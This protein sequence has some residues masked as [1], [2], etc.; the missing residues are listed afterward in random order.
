MSHFT[1]YADYLKHWLFK[2]VRETAMR[3]T[4]WRCELCGNPAT[5]VHHRKYPKPWG[6]FDVPANLQPVCRECH[7]RLEGL[8][9]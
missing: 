4:G 8:L 2:A 1:S 5:E 7:C 6:T 9:S 3:K